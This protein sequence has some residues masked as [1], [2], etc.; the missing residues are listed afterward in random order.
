MIGKAAMHLGA[1]RIKTGDTIDHT[2]GIILKKKF[3]DAVAI[4]DTIA[5]LHTNNQSKICEA[6]MLIN[7]AYSFSTTAPAKRDLIYKIIK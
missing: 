7:N 2:A 3:G 4:G 5:I 6:E 1:G